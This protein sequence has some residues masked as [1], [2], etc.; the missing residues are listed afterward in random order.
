MAEAVKKIEKYDLNL[1]PDRKK[2]TLE[3]EKL[4]KDG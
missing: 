3:L 2:A 1:E 4:K